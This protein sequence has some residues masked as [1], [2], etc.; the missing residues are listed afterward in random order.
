MSERTKKARFLANVRN[1]KAQATTLRLSGRIRD[2]VEIENAVDRRVREAE[3]L[4]FGD[5]ASGAEERGMFQ[6]ERAL[7]KG[8]PYRIR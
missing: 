1:L 4:G 5:D 7:R 3:I 2:A 8:K 6:A